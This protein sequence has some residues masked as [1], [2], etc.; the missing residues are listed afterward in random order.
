MTEIRVTVIDLF[1]SE[2][3]SFSAYELHT[4][5]CTDPGFLEV[6]AVS[7]R[8]I[9]VVKHPTRPVYGVMFHPEVRNEWV[10]KR[11]LSLTRK[12]RFNP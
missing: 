7:D 5:A 3:P 4:L 12:E 2:S 10:V 11:F 6:L 1:F 8:C 9:Q